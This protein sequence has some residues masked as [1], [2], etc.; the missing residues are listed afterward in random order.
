[1]EHEAKNLREIGDLTL[2]LDAKV[3][4]HNG[5]PLRIPL[6]Q[7]ELLCLL[8]ERDGKIVSK[9]EIFKT[10]WQES[11]VE[12]SN[13]T[14]QIYLLR[15]L[16]RQSGADEDLIQNIP[17]RGYRFAGHTPKI[18]AAFDLNTS[19]KTNRLLAGIE[20][21]KDFRRPAI[22]TSSDVSISK[23]KIL[24]FVS[25]TSVLL[26]AAIGWQL[27]RMT[28]IFHTRG[29]ASIRSIAVLP[30][31]SHSDID[32]S[33]RLRMTDSL[34]TRL[35]GIDRI[36]VRPTS[37]V[38]GFLNDEREA[39]ALGRLLM[40]DAVVES[41]L[42]K[43]GEIIRV[44]CRAVLSGSGEILWARQFD[45]QENQL[46]DLQD[47]MATE[48]VKYM[49]SMNPSDEP[50]IISSKPTENAEAYE[51]YLKGRY[52]WHKRSKDSLEKAVA[53]YENAVKLDPRFVDAY[54]GLAD[55]HF[56]IYEYI[57]DPSPSNVETAKNYLHEALKL[58]PENIQAFVTLG[59]IQTS[60]ER[61]WIAA[62]AS[63][64]TA[65]KAR[66][67]SADA[68]HRFAMLMLRL[69]RFEEAEAAMRKAKDIE[70]T[71]FAIIM[72][73]GL[74]LFSSGTTSE[75]VD[76]L[77]FAVELE[78]EIPAPYWYLARTYW[79]MGET[80][81]AFSTYIRALELSGHQKLAIR[82]KNDLG[83]KS[84]VEILSYWAEEW[85]KTGVDSYSLAI[86][87]AQQK[88]RSATLA[89]LEKA[90]KENNPWA[91]K[92]KADP[93]FGFIANEPRFQSILRELRLE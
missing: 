93:E 47:R 55:T 9:E 29:R 84:N 78:P 32:E 76:H 90:I 27:S 70:P 91:T 57:Y 30:F 73:L 53:F 12:E 46:L 1:M 33:L 43:E 45:G 2:D 23:R 51:S 86:L 24:I 21:E 6:K 18:E 28:I 38:K 4:W 36:N 74:V 22:K 54:T 59:L 65:L 66:P 92:I 87:K 40:V 80:S 16:L 39:R 14:R 49:D 25:L 52:F 48:L 58:D 11:F 17:K 81:E 82:I 89:L 67:N 50:F 3:L 13:L 77:R 85:T 69:G 60:Y 79:E 20:N 64:R 31:Q 42:Q 83:K 41:T 75:A 71:S 88:D 7:I 44:N 56:L 19:H 72:N 62:E 61:D 5:E 63:L 15:H 8:A 26:L 35:S 37:S 34:I 10:I 68:N